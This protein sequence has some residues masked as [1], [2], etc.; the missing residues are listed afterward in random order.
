MIKTILPNNSTNN[1]AVKDF[2]GD[3]NTN[4]ALLL[5]DGD[6]EYV[7]GANRVPVAQVEIGTGE[8]EYLHADVNGSV[9]A[10]TEQSGVLTGT[11]N[12]GAYGKRL[13][14]AI[15]RFGYAGEWT[16]PETSYVFLRARWY[17]PSMVTS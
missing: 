7:Y 6:Y 15:S 8:V 17:D 4:N 3:E 14:S 12:Y 2:V 10:A 16:D 9:I 5:S 11:T 13:G 1:V